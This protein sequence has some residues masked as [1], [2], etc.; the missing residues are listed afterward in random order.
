MRWLG[1][2]G[3]LVGHVLAS[4]VCAVWFVFTRR[5]ATLVFTHAPD[6]DRDGRDR[7][8]GPLVDRLI[9]DGRPIVEVTFISLD[10]DDAR[11]WFGNLRAKRRPFISH[12]A[13]LALGKCIGTGRAGRLFLRSLAPRAIYLIDE[14]GSGQMLVRA[15]RALG[16]R[17]IGVQHGDFQPENPQYAGTRGGAVEPVD[18]LAVWSPWFR[19][20][21]LR[22]SSIYDE[23]NTRVAGRARD[24]A[25][26]SV[27]DDET[28]SAAPENGLRALV[29]SEA[30][31]AFADEVAPFLDALRAEKAMTVAV[32]PHPGERAQ[33]WSH[34]ELTRGS[35][36]DELIRSDVAIGIASSAL[37]EALYYNRP[38]ICI[39]PER[40]SDRVGFV[41]DGAAIASHD[42][43]EFPE[44]IRELAKNMQRSFSGAKETVWGKAPRDPVAAILECETQP[45]APG[46]PKTRR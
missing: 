45:R 38:I 27:R 29:L 36:A 25:A 41:A 9:T 33:R 5:G 43:K 34:A 20:R 11:G 32:R 14:S 37:L 10:G 22:I 1:R 12:A 15:A 24:D 28:A 44:M 30:N 19:A 13:L 23:S 18:V 42:P 17:T 21:L 40:G 26:L 7:Q 3:R 46:S 2:A 16:I 39:E 31:D 8:M 4:A 6:I 35:L